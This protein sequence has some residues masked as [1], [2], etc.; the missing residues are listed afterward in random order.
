VAGGEGGGSGWLKEPPTKPTAE[1]YRHHGKPGRVGEAGSCP[2]QG[3]DPI[4]QGLAEGFEG[5]ATELGELVEEEDAV[6]G[7]ADLSG[8]GDAAADEAHVG[9]GVMGRAEGAAGEEG[10]A[11]GEETG[12]GV[13]FSG[14]Q[15]LVGG[16]GRKDGGEALGQHG[17]PRA[18]RPHQM[19]VWVRTPAKRGYSPSSDEVSQPSIA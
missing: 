14:F 7:E 17:L 18:G 8:A 6:M 12:D 19:H 16:E 15:R 1:Q 4:L 2:C 3:H 9:D 5:V 11:G 13:E 10:L